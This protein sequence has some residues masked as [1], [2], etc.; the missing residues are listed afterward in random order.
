MAFGAIDK[1]GAV[2]PMFKYFAIFMVSMTFCA[3]DMRNFFKARSLNVYEQMDLDRLSTFNQIEQKLNMYERCIEF[4]PDCD[5]PNMKS[6]M[7]ELKESD[8]KDLRYVLSK[9]QNR[10]EYDRTEI[11]VRKGKEH[12]FLKSAG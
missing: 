8:I 7:Y 3:W 12:I 10:A 6:P 9:P 11:F 4:E 5:D 1:L 2:K